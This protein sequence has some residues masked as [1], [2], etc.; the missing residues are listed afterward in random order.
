M[1]P[2]ENKQTMEIAGD[3][4]AYRKSAL[5]GCEYARS[6]FW[7]NLVHRDLR[8]RGWK[9]SLAADMRVRLGTCPSAWM[10]CRERY[11]HGR[12]FG[13]TR[14]G[15]SLLTRLVRILTAPAL[16]PFL[17]LRIG[18]RIAMHRR[19]WLAKYIV[20]LPWLV[21]FV[22]SWSAGETIGYMQ[23]RSEEP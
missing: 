3:N 11:L 20:T 8:A 21:F 6:G 7:E 22:C 4:A 16:A 10:F 2:V 14:P 5:A 17:V 1:P 18:S 9:L 15:R 23:P 19:D 12:Y 13:S